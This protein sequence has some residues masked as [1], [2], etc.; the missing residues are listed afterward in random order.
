FIVMIVQQ[1]PLS[2]LLPY[3]TLFRSRRGS[4]RRHLHHALH[5]APVAG[6][7]ADV[8]IVPALLRR[9]ELESERLLRIDEL[10][11]H[12]HVGRGR[13][14][15]DRKGTGLNSSHLVI[16]YADFCCI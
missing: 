4:S 11:G 8:R 1:H 12:D 14:V 2:T 10:R 9:D 13:D 15:L 3:T 16:W 5:D 7:G 6:E